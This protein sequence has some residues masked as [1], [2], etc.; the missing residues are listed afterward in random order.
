MP[1]RELFAQPQAQADFRE[2]LESLH[3]ALTDGKRDSNEVV[4]D[5]LYGIF[6]GGD[7]YPLALDGLSPAGRAMVHSLDPRNITTEPEYYADI[8]GKAYMERKPFIWLWQM[9][10]RSPLGQN[11]LLGH[12]LRRMLAPLIFRRVGENFKCWQ[13]VEWSF[14]Y[15]LSFGDNVVIHRHVLLDDRGGI[16]IGNNVSISDYA[17]IYSHTHD[18][19]DIATVY[20]RT[21]RIGNC[22]RITYHATVLAGVQIGDHAML[23][24][25]AI[26]TEN[27]EP[28]HIKVGVPAKTVKVKSGAAS[29]ASDDGFSMMPLPKL[30][31]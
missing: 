8:D 30:P 21:T 12:Q 9:F 22:A 3:T 4:R 27:I 24:S 19:D 7:S 25:G 18:I 5:T 11:A 6:F 2:F 15:N 16:E 28:Y 20:N 1:Y 29:G 10:D 17:N 13:F 26:A 31:Q 23:G 14:G